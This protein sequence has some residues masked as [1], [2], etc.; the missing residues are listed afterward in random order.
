MTA[1]SASGSGRA[2]PAARQN[3]ASPSTEVALGSTARAEPLALVAVTAHV[4]A[5]AIRDGV[6]SA[7]GVPGCPSVG[8]RGA[9]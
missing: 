2:V 9:G 6:R 1:T 4:V 5:A 7:T 8:E 3:A